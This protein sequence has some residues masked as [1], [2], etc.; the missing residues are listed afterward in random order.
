[1]DK[2]KAADNLWRARHLIQSV[3][4]TGEYATSGTVGHADALL[5]FDGD[6]YALITSLSQAIERLKKATALLEIVRYDVT[7]ARSLASQ[8]EQHEG[9]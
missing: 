7:V 1:M 2:D 3:T 5:R 6:Q 4:K 8:E 9:G